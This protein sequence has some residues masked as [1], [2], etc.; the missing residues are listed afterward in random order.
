M[1]KKLTDAERKEKWRIE[2]L[3]TIEKYKN[4]PVKEILKKQ[5][6]TLDDFRSKAMRRDFE[7]YSE[8]N[9][10]MMEKMKLLHQHK[11]M[12]KMSGFQLKKLD[13]RYEKLIGSLRDKDNE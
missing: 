5:T 1:G 2:R 9:R 11:V 6:K 7:K 12:K 13:V 4:K 8:K 10:V 3:K